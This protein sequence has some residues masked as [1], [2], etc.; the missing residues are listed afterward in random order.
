MNLTNKEVSGLGRIGMGDLQGFFTHSALA[1]ETTGVPLGLLYQKIY[2]R[3]ELS[4][5][6]KK[7]Y[8]QMPIEEK[9]TVRWI[10]TIT[11][12][13]KELKDKRVVI[14]GDRESDIYEVFQKAKEKK[15][16]LLIRTA[17]NRI[18]F[19]P[20]NT[21]DTEYL[22]EKGKKGRIVTTYTAQVPT[23]EHSHTTREALLTIKT[24]SFLLPLPTNKRKT[25]KPDIPL[26]F[27]DIT[28]ENPPEGS[29]PIHWMLT[30]T[31]E[32]KTPEEAIEKVQWYIYRWRTVSLHFKD[33][34]VQCGETAI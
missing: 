5:E 26:Y 20:D 16:D 2:V 21:R 1:M 10:E 31:L 24:C 11:E 25:G 30:T 9:E 22:F 28:E 18:V 7:H 17:R 32:I 27:L 23:K 19:D 12:V 8:K 4:K 3:K 6:R 15:K 14:I 33:R 13:S 34:S 29:E